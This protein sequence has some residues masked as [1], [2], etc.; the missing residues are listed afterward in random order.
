MGDGFE[1][2]NSRTGRSEAELDDLWRRYRQAFGEPDGSP[3]FMPNL[4]L[5][6]E[7]RRSRFR[8]FER[9]ARFLAVAA[10]S[11]ALIL[12]GLVAVEGVRQT[13]QWHAESYV[14][15]LSADNA[16][17]SSFYIE[18]VA[19]ELDPAAEREGR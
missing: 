10:A 1:M 5:R 4:W 17:A 13:R 15:V 8:A 6:I 18:P 7:A 14:E 3:L 2:N 11:L 12:G 9:G 16:R 19:F